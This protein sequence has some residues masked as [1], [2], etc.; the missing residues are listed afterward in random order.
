MG[1]TSF[2]RNPQ[3]GRVVVAQPPNPPLV[4]FLGGTA[5]RWVFS[6][7]GTAGDA[8]SVVTTAALA[9]W[10]IDEILRGESPFRRVLGAVVLAGIGVRLAP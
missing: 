2:F 7:T 9:W 5:A 1:V 8:L 10:S 4:V 3:T 6:P